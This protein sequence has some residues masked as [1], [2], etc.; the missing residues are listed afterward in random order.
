[1]K[2]SRSSFSKCLWIYIRSTTY[3]DGNSTG[4]FINYMTGI[5]YCAHE[6]AK[7]FIWNL[8]IDLFILLFIDFVNELTDELFKLFQSDN[9]RLVFITSFLESF[10]EILLLIKAR[11]FHNLRS[12]P[13]RNLIKL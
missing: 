5:L 9:I 12:K 2:G 4:S 3:P 10:I 13:L 6:I 1:M 11:I 7:I 8:S